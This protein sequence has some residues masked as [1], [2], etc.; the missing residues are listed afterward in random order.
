[1]EE[2][3][4]DLCVIYGITISLLN[5]SGSFI[6]LEIHMIYVVESAKTLRR[7]LCFPASDRATHIGVNFSVLIFQCLDIF[8][9]RVAHFLTMLKDFQSSLFLSQLYYDILESRS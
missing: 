4:D 3:Y 9:N 8:F 7:I 5:S 6:C 1:M 2:D